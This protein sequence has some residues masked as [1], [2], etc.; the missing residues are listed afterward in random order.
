LIQALTLGQSN[1]VELG[2]ILMTGRAAFLILSP[3]TSI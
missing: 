2:I 3:A 1:R